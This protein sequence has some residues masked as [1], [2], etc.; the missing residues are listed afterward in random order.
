[1]KKIRVGMCGLGFMGWTHLT[2]YAGFRNVEVTAIC[3]ASARRFTGKVEG[4]IQQTGNG[5]E[6]LK[7]TRRYDTLDEML[8]SE[9]LDMV[10]ICAPT[11][12]HARLACRALA[13]GV[14]VLCEKPMALSVPE[15]DRMIRAARKAGRFLMVA[16][17]LRWWPEYV[18]LHRLVRSARFGVLK[19]LHLFRGS[20]PT[21]WAPWMT[22]ERKS[23]G[24][25]LDL[26]IH[27]LD[28]VLWLLGAP[29]AVAASLSR[30]RRAG[31]VSYRYRDC[32]VTAEYNANLR[33]GFQFNMTYR[34]QFEHATLVFDFS[35][36]QPL[37]LWANGK[38]SFPKLPSANA[39]AAEI[40]YFTDGIRRGRAPRQLTP[41]EARNGIALALL[42]KK[43][44]ERGQWIRVKF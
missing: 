29:A 5:S 40:R 10:D 37:T 2:A 38:Q 19:S 11:F 26:H 30:D 22:D 35:Q 32:V 3:H 27:D 31:S 20:M 24:P 21:S 18:Y 1:M 36:K 8:S 14:H 25:L 44:A 6:I 28:Q 34:A 23:G 41:K 12:T 7:K 13:A 42:E 39:Y 43:A 15:C 4:N 16:H 33:G 9:N 17:C